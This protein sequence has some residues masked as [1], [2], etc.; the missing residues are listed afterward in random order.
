[1]ARGYGQLAYAS[2]QFTDRGDAQTSVYVCRNITTNATPTELLLD[3]AIERMSIP[4]NATWSFDI[5]V[6]GRTATGKSAG[7]Q[8]RGAI[9]R[10]E[11]TAAF[12]G[13]PSINVLGE[14]I[15]DWDASVNTNQQKDALVVQVTGA[16]DTTIRWVASV[17]T[18]E[19]IF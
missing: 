1:M 19:V 4:E 5:L 15:A 11:G 8:I 14:D 17:R 13:T 16:G 6:T 18:V 3:G 2:G 7:Y 9:A 12:I 10:V